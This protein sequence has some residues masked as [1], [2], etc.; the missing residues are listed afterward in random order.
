MQSRGPSRSS[1]SAFESAFDVIWTAVSAVGTAYS[2]SQAVK[3]LKTR[4][5]GAKEVIDV[6]RGEWAARGGRPAD[7]AQILNGRP[8]RSGEVANLLG[9]G[10]SEAEALLWGLGFARGEDGMWHTDNDSD[11][12]LLSFAARLASENGEIDTQRIR[13]EAHAILDSRARTP[14]LGARDDAPTDEPEL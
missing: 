8:R 2:A 9:C 3:A 11:A 1:W 7:L 4:L 5:W 13:T 6:H 14:R 10:E 12:Q